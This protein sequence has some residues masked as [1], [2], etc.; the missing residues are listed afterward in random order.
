LTIGAGCSIF[1]ARKGVL[2]AAVLQMAKKRVYEAAKELGV[3]SQRM[4]EMLREVGIEK[5]NVF[6][7]IAEEEYEVITELFAKEAATKTKVE[8]PPV[9][10]EPEKPLGEPRPPVVTVLGHIDHGKT[11][12]LD[13]IRKTRVAASEAGGITQSIGAYQVEYNSKKIT[14]IDTPGHKAFTAMR[15]RGASVTDLVILVVA[16]DDGVMMQTKEAIA[17]ARAAKVPIIVAINKIDKPGINVDKVKEQLTKEGLKPEDWGGDTIT[18]PISALT[19]KNIPELLEMILLLA[20]LQDLRADPKKKASGTII[21]GYLDL[22]KGPVASAIIKDGTL[23]E[24]EI[25][26]A[27]AAYG[28]IRALLNDRGQ[29]IR[30]ALPGMPVQILGLS[31]VPPAGVPLEVLD[32]LEEAKELA[33]SRE[34]ERR[35]KRLAST[36]RSLADFLA[37]AVKKKKLLLILKAEAKGS[38]EALEGEL[39]NLAVEGISLELLHTGVGNIT[40][41]DVLLAASTEEKAAIIGFRVDID[42]EV[43]ELAEQEGI[44]VRTYDVIYKITEDV[45][46]AMRQMVEPKYR[47]VKQ[48]LVEVRH[49]FKISGIGTVAGCY[50][51]EGIVLKEAKARVIRDGARVF[52]GAIRSLKRF[53]EDVRRVEQGKEC[54]IKLADFEDVQIGDTLEIFTLEEVKQ[55]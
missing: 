43:A 40:E 41:N 48:G 29:R 26:V 44:A 51:Q 16:A 47:E 14:F 27:G 45:E 7:T 37:Q 19:G 25:I 54:G 2:Q 11:T 10:K 36:R 32:N 31:D 17:H 6:H 23:R 55:L 20:E 46:K 18:V 38:L 3:S 50:V 42:K 15:A 5:S 53:A 30:E 52:E 4:L 28:R 39:R 34:E 9:K 24:R 13:W 33:E 21:E 1:S 8:E 49:V 22:T 35:K 12:L